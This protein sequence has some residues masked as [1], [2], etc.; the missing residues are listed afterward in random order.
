[1]YLLYERLTPEQDRA[2]HMD[3]AGEVEGLRAV[4]DGTGRVQKEEN[5]RKVDW[6]LEND[7]M[8]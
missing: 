6:N 5:E 2:G 3:S 4:R 8:E 1:M 7:C